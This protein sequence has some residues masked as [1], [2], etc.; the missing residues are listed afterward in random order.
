MLDTLLS[1][2]GGSIVGLAGPKIA[3]LTYR[4]CFSNTFS[5]TGLCSI[6]FSLHKIHSISAIILF[7]CETLSILLRF[8]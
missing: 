6:L 1:I 8:A 3:H 5:H 2:W 4:L 7:L